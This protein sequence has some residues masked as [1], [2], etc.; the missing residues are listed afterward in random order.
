M[1]RALD[2]V[3]KSTDPSAQLWRAG[4]R[5][6]YDGIP[7]RRIEAASVYDDAFDDFIVSTSCVRKCLE[8]CL[9]LREAFRV[10]DEGFHFPRIFESVSCLRS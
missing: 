7:V 8:L 6:R 4:R 5:K 3:A 9:C 2:Y 1:D 10:Y